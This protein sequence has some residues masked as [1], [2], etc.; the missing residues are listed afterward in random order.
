M[1]SKTTYHLLIIGAI[2][3]FL[4]SCSKPKSKQ[5]KWETQRGV[6]IAPGITEEDFKVLKPMGANNVRIAFAIQPFMELEPPYT[7][8]ERAFENLG[9]ILDLGEKYGVKVVIDPHRFPGTWHPWTMINN[10]KFWTDFNWHE[11]AIAIWERIAIQCK[12][13]GEVI[14]GY[15]LLNEPAVPKDFKENTP[16]DIN[17]LYRKL[18]AAIRKHDTKH[19]IILAGPRYTPPGEEEEK[20][21]IFGLDVLEPL[22]DDNLCYTIHMYDPKSFTHQGVWEESEFIKYPDFVD[23]ADWNKDKIRSYMQRAKDF[24]EKHN[25]PIYIG[26]F[27]CP[28][29]TGDYGNQY[30]KD[31]IEVYEEYGFS[32]AY[33]AFRENQLWDIEMSNYD[34]TDTIRVETTPRKELLIK[35]FSL[36]K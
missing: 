9:R 14:A 12:D 18:I 36:N 2:T 30:L 35:A 25:A 22:V 6:N 17:F 29:W 10:D 32:W 16:G 4:M 21:Y 27:S 31:L 34:K 3:L 20:V 8:N 7:F 13:R 15:D 19:T 5:F 33:H 1:N 23:G 24:S 11:K 26:E 28:R